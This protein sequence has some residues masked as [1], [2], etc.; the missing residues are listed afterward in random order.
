MRSAKDV[1]YD[2]AFRR[3][4]GCPRFKANCCKS[5]AI[6][7]GIEFFQVNLVMPFA[8]QSRGGAM[9][10]ALFAFIVGCLCWS[11][12]SLPAADVEEARQQF[13]QG[14]YSNCIQL[15]Q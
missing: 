12:S 8:G 6:S 7:C 10:N 2:K 9:M 14:H 11:A 13:I 5:P 1:G 3:P 15:C 4:A